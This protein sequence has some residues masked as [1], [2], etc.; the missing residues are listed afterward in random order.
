M[1]YHARFGHASDI[2]WIARQVA[3]LGDYLGVTG[4]AGERRRIWPIVQ[5]SD[6]GEPV[7]VGHVAQVI[8]LGARRPATGVMVFAWSGLRKDPGKIEAV[9]RAFRALVTG[10]SRG[11]GRE[12]ALALADAGA[13]IVITGRTEETLDATATDIRQR[14]R[15][16]RTVRADMGRPSECER[17]CVGILREHGPIDI[18]IN[19]VGNR[20]GSHP[21][22]ED[23]LETWRDVIDLNL[24]SYGIATRIFGRA[25]LERGAGGRVINTASISA[26]IAN[27]GIGGRGCETAKAAVLHFT[28]CAAVDWAPHGITV[29]AIC[30]ASS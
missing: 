5:V 22:V 11:L 1:V 27:R 21:I 8:E 19:N 4:V 28:R 25:M 12:M 24:T 7:P 6:W 26:L 18:L 15:Q 13:D 10:A 14:G 9:G 29:N 16:V 23:T 17:A 30:P 3:W 20:V 2:A